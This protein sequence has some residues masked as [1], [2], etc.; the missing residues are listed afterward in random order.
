[1]DTMSKV[2]SKHSN[3]LNPYIEVDMGDQQRTSP[4]VFGGLFSLHRMGQAR[5]VLTPKLLE[6][7]AVTTLST[8]SRVQGERLI[9]VGICVPGSIF[10]AI[11]VMA[12]E[13]EFV[14]MCGSPPGALHTLVTT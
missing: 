4:K 6:L 3:T 11:V 14:I 10:D 13:F 7:L 2:Y 8:K 5:L 12:S 9:L 1:M